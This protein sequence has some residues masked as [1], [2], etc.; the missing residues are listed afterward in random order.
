MSGK[1]SRRA[2]RRAS[3]QPCSRADYYRRLRLALGVRVEEVA[4]AVGCSISYVSALEAGRRPFLDHLDSEFESAFR[5]LLSRVH[6]DARR[7]EAA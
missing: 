4:A 6:E 5:Q 2:N 3:S 1:T 7:L